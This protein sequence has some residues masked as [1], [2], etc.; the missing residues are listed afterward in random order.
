MA[1]RSELSEGMRVTLI[2]R[3]ARGESQEVTVID[4]GDVR[5]SMP[6]DDPMISQTVHDD[7]ALVQDEDGR[8]IVAPLS[9][10]EVPEDNPS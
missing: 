8:Y 3:Y 9:N 2:G 7:A 1:D 4:E 6:G 10:L 5:L